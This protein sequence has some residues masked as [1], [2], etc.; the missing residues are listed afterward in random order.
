M[1][2]C[3]GVSG[4]LRKV[5]RPSPPRR[6]TVAP[7]GPREGWSLK[8]Q[9]AVRLT[10]GVLGG[11]SDGASPSSRRAHIV[12]LGFAGFRLGVP[13]AARALSGAVAGSVEAAR[14]SR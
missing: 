8:R 2:L 3:R 5:A 7:H 14:R 9:R 1:R 4:L 12:A 11:L 10:H 13:A 6:K